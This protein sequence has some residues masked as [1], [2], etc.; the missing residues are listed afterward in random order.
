MDTLLPLKNAV[1]TA[2]AVLWHTSGSSC[3]FLKVMLGRSQFRRSMR[4]YWEHCRA[5]ERQV[6]R[7]QFAWRDTCFSC[8]HSPYQVTAWEY[9]KLRRKLHRSSSF[10]V[11]FICW[12]SPATHFNSFRFVLLLQKPSPK[13]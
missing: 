12:T 11:L 1:S 3:P 10:I 2:R 13:L 4:A 5:L 6:L 7:I 8:P 9:C